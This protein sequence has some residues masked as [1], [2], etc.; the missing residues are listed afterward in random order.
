MIPGWRA[1][2]QSLFAVPFK[3]ND[4]DEL[5]SVPRYLTPSQLRVEWRKIDFGFMTCTFYSDVDKLIQEKVQ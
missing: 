2:C 1:A 3:Q 5:K 4:D